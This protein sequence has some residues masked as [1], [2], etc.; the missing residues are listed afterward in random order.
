MFKLENIKI[1]YYKDEF[2]R[3]CAFITNYVYKRAKRL[4]V[5]INIANL[6]SVV[7]CIVLSCIMT[8]ILRIIMT[9]SLNPTE[10][11]GQLII[12]IAINIISVFIGKTLWYNIENDPFMDE[13][14]LANDI[15]PTKDKTRKQ[16]FAEKYKQHREQ[17]NDKIFTLHKIFSQAKDDEIKLAIDNNKMLVIT[18]TENGIEKEFALYVD[19][20]FNQSDIDIPLEQ[21]EDYD[22]I[23]ITPIYC[24]VVLSE[25]SDKSIANKPNL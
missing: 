18:Y 22:K 24:I 13:Y 21:P 6:M 16:I 2:D 20:V 10:W 14:V 17:M 19:G 3:A 12:L 7:S 4:K 11:W 5:K 15:V 9:A 23:I 1:H 8:H 25:T